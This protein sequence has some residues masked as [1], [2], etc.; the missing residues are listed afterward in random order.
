M[1]SG[2]QLGKDFKAIDDGGIEYGSGLL[3]L[4][5]AKLSD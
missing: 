4:F 3:R 1:F 2:T 5:E